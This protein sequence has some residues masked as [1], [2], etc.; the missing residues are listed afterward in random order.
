LGDAGVATG[1]GTS[2]LAAFSG[3]GGMF[4]DIGPRFKTS[5]L[6][7]GPMVRAVKVSSNAVQPV[8][9]FMISKGF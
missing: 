6:Y 5:K 9:E 4:C 7:L 2:T 8:L 3:G 1:S